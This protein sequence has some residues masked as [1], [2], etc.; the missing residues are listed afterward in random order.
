MIMGNR[1]LSASLDCRPICPL[2]AKRLG[3]QE[4]AIGNHIRAAHGPLP[5]KVINKLYK[6]SRATYGLIN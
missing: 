6:Y 1:N 5:Q 4:L 2:C 3:M